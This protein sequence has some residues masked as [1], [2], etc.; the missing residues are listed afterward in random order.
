MTSFHAISSD[1]VGILTWAVLRG[2]RTGS[3]RGVT[4]TGTALGCANIS[5]AALRIEC[6]R[7]SMTGIE[8]NFS[9][10][11]CDF[12]NARSARRF[13]MV[14]RE[15][16]G[17][18]FSFSLIGVNSVGVSVVAEILLLVQILGIDMLTIADGIKAGQMLVSHITEVRKLKGCES[19]EAVV[20]IESN[21]YGWAPQLIQYVGQNQL[22]NVRFIRNDAVPGTNG[23]EIRPGSRTTSTSKLTGVNYMNAILENR[24]LLVHWKFVS[25]YA[26]LYPSNFQELLRQLRSFLRIAKVNPNAITKRTH[27]EFSGKLS[28]KDDMAMTMIIGLVEMYDYEVKQRV[29]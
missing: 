24:T 13:A 25:A 21:Y 23:E 1:D 28:G 17:H 6:S 9:L 8:A 3:D 15:Q 4:S 18:P 7:V 27:V 16:S 20:A 11:C 10:F 19:A 2:G 22:S 5:R 29:P 12:S 14:F 26:S